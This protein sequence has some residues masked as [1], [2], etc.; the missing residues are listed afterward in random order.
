MHFFSKFLPSLES[1]KFLLI[2]VFLPLLVACGGSSDSSP[3]SQGEKI[4]NPLKSI[5]LTAGTSQ[6]T[7][8]WTSNGASSYEI[9][10]HTS[11]STAGLTAIATTT[12]VSY[13]DTG[14]TADTMY[15]Y[16]VK[17][18]KENLDGV[19]ACSDFSQVA[20]KTT[21]ILP[22]DVPTTL[23]LSA[24]STSQITVSWT[25]SNEATSYKLY[26]N[27]NN[28]STN[29][30]AIATQTNTSYEDTGLTVDTTYYYWVKACKE[31]LDGVKAC[32]DFSTGR[33]ETTP[34]SAPQGLSLSADSVSQ[35]TVSWDSVTGAEYYEIY[36]NTSNTN[37]TLTAFF[38]PMASS[39]TTY[40]DSGLISNTQ[41]YYWLKACKTGNDCSVFSEMASTKTQIIIEKINDTGITW[42]GNYPSGN[43]TGTSCSP[44]GFATDTTKQ[45]CHQG[46]DAEAVDG[47]LT[48]VGGGNAG[49]DFTKLG[50]TGT[51]LAIQGESWSSTGTE[52]AGTQWSCVKDNHTGLIWEVKTDNGL[53]GKDDRY[54]WYNTD[55]AS[56]GGAV[57][58]ADDD[59][60]VCEGYQSGDSAT[61]CNTQ[62][63]V[64][65]VN[66][67]TLCGASDWRMPTRQE[68]LSITHFGRFKPSIDSHYFPNTV[69]D[70]FWS[71]VPYANSSVNAWAVSFG[72]GYDRNAGHVSDY[73]VRLVRASQ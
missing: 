14:L 2:A 47:K 30:T 23:T 71:S 24:D 32:S 26:R 12:N 42:S 6:I 29:L 17:A 19:Q 64:A 33:F 31:N 13:K 55:S 10:R 11:N 67:A 70:W 36:R 65:R 56:N 48:K 68:F 37:T 22:P 49:F 21:L 28:S 40:I 59:G 51:I 9:Y 38:S 46:R 15:Y 45:D 20:S 58:D 69:S 39:G 5:E 57:G 8:S 72:Y 43:S 73:R 18:C 3:P 52:A 41:Y 27:T 25:T 44:T 4:I 53:H 16:W 62:A 1:F 63:F 54:N 34:L 66:Q 50:S 61:Y 60:N 7:V 35:L